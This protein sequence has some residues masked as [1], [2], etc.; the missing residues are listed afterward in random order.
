MF[1]FVLC[2]TILMIVL[3]EV[4][5]GLTDSTAD[6]NPNESNLGGSSDADPNDP[7]VKKA[8]EL[9][10]TTLEESNNNSPYK[11]IVGDVLQVKTQV[12]SGTTYYL[13]FQFSQTNCFKNRTSDEVAVPCDIMKTEICLAEV[14]SPLD[15]NEMEIE[16]LVCDPN[17]T[18]Y[19]NVEQPVKIGAIPIPSDLPDSINYT[20]VQYGVCGGFAVLMDFNG[21]F[22]NCTTKPYDWGCHK[23]WCWSGC[24]VGSFNINE[25][26]Y[27][28]KTWSQSYDYVRCGQKYDCSPDWKCG[29]PCS[30]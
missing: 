24:Q 25:W 21:V 28:T 9:V 22:D 26:C 29:G 7:E 20:N 18:D 12:V 17:L 3:S 27:T 30:L 2:F 15:V 16:S 11:Y 23:G 14:L 19:S 13:S 8:F 4:S 1:K 6:Q 5:V 10:K